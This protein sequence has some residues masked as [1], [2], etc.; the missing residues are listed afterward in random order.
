MSEQREYDVQG[1][2]GNKEYLGVISNFFELK[3]RCRRSRE[4]LYEERNG[5]CLL[6]VIRGSLIIPGKIRPMREEGKD[7]F[8]SC[9][10]LATL[11][12]SSQDKDNTELEQ[13]R[14]S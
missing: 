12:N 2:R 10:T 11:M 3:M 7:K 5:H 1:R 8:F 9:Q 4:Y 6:S 13:Y 14:E